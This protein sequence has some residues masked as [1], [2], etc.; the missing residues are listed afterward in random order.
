MF[1]L[2]LH[3]CL[4][5]EPAICA[6]RLLPAPAPLTEEECRST[7]A[8]R[9]ASWLLRHPEL[10]PGPSRCAPTSDLPQLALKEVAPGVLVHEGQDGLPDTANRGEIANLG[11]VIGSE[12][13]AV[14]DAGASRA[15]AEALFAAIRSRSDLPIRAL[16]LTHMHPD[17][18]FGADLFREVGAEILGAPRLAAGIEARAA[19]WM[20]SYPPQVG[21]GALLGTRVALPDRGTADETLELGDAT[22]HL[23]AVATAH[24]DNDLTVFHAQSGTLFAGDLVFNELLPTLDGSVNGWLAW[25][26]EPRPEVRRIVA[27]H[28]PAPVPWPDGAQTTRAYLE[29]LRTT[30]RTAI[31]AGQPMSVAIRDRDPDEAAR[32]QAYDTS[33]PRNV[34][35]AYAE[36]EWE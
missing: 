35:A 5:A 36:L 28:G 1:H 23:R 21:T 10:T 31:A 34:S 29:R 30:I 13:I 2:L 33:H 15:Q 26:D 25:L 14:I 20:E 18:S 9:A 3:A 8:E 19:T 24:T 6:E 32:W 4:A 27:G 7:A 16:I 22:L 12:D 17:H 11:V